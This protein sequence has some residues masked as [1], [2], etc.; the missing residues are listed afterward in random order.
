LSL[1]TMGTYVARDT[2]GLFA[3]AQLCQLPSQVM[4]DPVG[5]DASDDG[6]L[7]VAMARGD[8]GAASSFYDRH[9]PT[10]MALVY[11][12]VGDRTD[13]ES[14]V[15]EAFMQAWRTAARFDPLRGSPASWLF[16]IARTRALDFLRTTRRQARLVPVSVDDVPGESLAAPGRGGPPGV[17]GEESERRRAVADALRALPDNQRIAI[18]LA[19]FEGLSH[20]EIAERLSEPLGTVKTRVR[21]GMVKL[22]EVLRPYAE[23]VS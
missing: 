12:M 23:A 22:R 21:L 15:L 13:A 19:Y 7:V 20:S 2:A 17:D 14:I 1:S 9:S 8:E 4:S 18:E 16:T 6:A 10:V 11:R 3:G 5:R